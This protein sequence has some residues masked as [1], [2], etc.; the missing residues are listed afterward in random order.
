ME[1]DEETPRAENIKYYTAEETEKEQA[2]VSS[3]R[4]SKETPTNRF[5]LRNSLEL[6]RVP[7]PEMTKT[8][9]KAKTLYPKNRHHLDRTTVIK[10]G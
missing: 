1:T 9:N 4:S 7:T 6:G 2:V 3:N 8:V 10:P 5:G